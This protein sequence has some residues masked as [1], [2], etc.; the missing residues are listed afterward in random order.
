MTSVLIEWPVNEANIDAAKSVRALRETVSREP[1][2]S[3]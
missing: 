2:G 1:S 3:A